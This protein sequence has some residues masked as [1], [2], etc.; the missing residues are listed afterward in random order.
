MAFASLMLAYQCILAIVLQCCARQ[1]L[2][3]L[4]RRRS[5]AKLLAFR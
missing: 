3:G 5:D 1:Q 2:L 4:K